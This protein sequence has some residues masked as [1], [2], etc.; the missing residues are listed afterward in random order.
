MIYI[1]FNT[2]KKIYFLPKQIKILYLG[3][4][5]NK[6]KVYFSCKAKY[7]ITAIMTTIITITKNT[8]LLIKNVKKSP[9]ENIGNVIFILNK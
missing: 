8:G 6:V 4:H 3:S 9:P 5:R 2:Y 7:K 1:I